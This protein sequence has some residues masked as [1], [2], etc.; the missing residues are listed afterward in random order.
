MRALLDESANPDLQD[1]RGMSALMRAVDHPGTAAVELLLEQGART[2][3]FAKDGSS[4][5]TL[6]ARRNRLDVIRL[7]LAFGANKAGGLNQ[8]LIDEASAR[9]HREVAAM[10]QFFLE[11]YNEEH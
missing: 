8:Q 10:L 2:N 6:A 7:L 1:A 5:L 4:C 9:G 3:L 11:R